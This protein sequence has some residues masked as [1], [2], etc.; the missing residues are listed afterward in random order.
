MSSL[1][2]RIQLLEESQATRLKRNSYGSRIKITQEMIDEHIKK[3][4]NWKFDGNNPAAK[5]SDEEVWDWL[6]KDIERTRRMNKNP[7]HREQFKNG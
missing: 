3:T 4:Q 6:Q 1:T 7:K 2:K 5:M